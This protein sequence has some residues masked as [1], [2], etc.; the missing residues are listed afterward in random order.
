MASSAVF[1]RALCPFAAKPLR[2]GCVRIVVS[3]ANNDADLLREVESELQFIFK[4]SASA[5]AADDADA[6]TAKPPVIETT[7]VVVPDPEYLDTYRYFPEIHVR[8]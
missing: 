7:L 3:S 4:E 6:V 1:G 2:S 5:G 8:S